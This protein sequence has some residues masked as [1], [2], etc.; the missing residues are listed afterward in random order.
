KQAT[1]AKARDLETT[2]ER[3]RAGLPTVQT[4]RL[5]E[6]LNKVI[7]SYLDELRRLGRSD[8]HVVNEKGF[9]SRLAKHCSWLTLSC[10]RADK[11]TA[12]L[13]EV[14]RQGKSPRTQNA[15]RDS[16]VAF[17]N[18]CVRQNWLK[19]NPVA[20]IPKAS[21]KGRQPRQRRAFTPDEFRWL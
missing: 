9:L 10:I 21:M 2:A 5:H 8:T 14:S 4:D 7:D 20:R 11:L 15:Y 19:E 16:A 12:F 1:L 3:S 6:P 17:C 13:A 18:F